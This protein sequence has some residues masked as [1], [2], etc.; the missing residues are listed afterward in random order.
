MDTR[1]D[2]AVHSVIIRVNRSCILNWLGKGTLGF[3]EGNSIFF[4]S[5]V[6]LVVVAVIIVVGFFLFCLCILLS[7]SFQ[8]IKTFFL[9]LCF[10]A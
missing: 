5:L 9:Y 4:F 6:F 10:I 1:Y 2:L 8:I 3:A 7:R